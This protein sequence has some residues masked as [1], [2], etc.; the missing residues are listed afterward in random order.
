[1][2]VVDRRPGIRPRATLGRRLDLAARHAVPVSSTILLMLLTELPF[3]FAGQTVLLPALTIGCVWFWSLYRPTAMPPPAVF[4][5][6][7]LL[8]L[9]GYLPLGVSVLTLLSVHGAAVRW[10][11][12]LAEQGFG[13]VWLAFV[14]VGV[15]SAGLSW[16]VTAVLMFRLLPFAPAIF[17]AVLSI[18]LYPLLAIPL[19][20]AHHGVADPDRA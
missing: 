15:L 4:L 1:M 18:A 3:G 10:R 6:G 5:I 17:Q 8:D 14:P 16:A 2:A 9:L 20:R 7:V 11:R 12:S 19:A 13:V